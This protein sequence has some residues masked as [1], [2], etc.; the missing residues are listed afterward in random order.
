M[1]ERH[2]L[3]KPKR[4]NSRNNIYRN[5]NDISLRKNNTTFSKRYQ[6]LFFS[7]I[8]FSTRD[9]KKSE[10]EINHPTLGKTTPL[11]TVPLRPLGSEISPKKFNKPSL[12]EEESRFIKIAQGNHAR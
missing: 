4:P 11:I 8:L 3:A 1:V 9:R 6:K 10:P 5:E 7:S 2:P 12:K